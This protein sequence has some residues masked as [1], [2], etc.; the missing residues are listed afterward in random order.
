MADTQ[1]HRPTLS[2]LSEEITELSAS[3]GE[4]VVS[5]NSRGGFPTSG[6]IWEPG[7]VVTADHVLHLD[8]GLRVTLADGTDLEAELAGRDPSTDLALLKVA[9]SAQGFGSRTESGNLKPGTLAVSL[10]RNS[11]KSLNASLTVINAIGGE[12]RSPFGGTIDNYLRL[13]VTVHAGF[14]GGPLVDVSGALI[15]I[16]SSRLSRQSPVAIPLAT[17]ERVVSELKERGH[18]RQGY[19]GLA[20]FPI[21]IDEALRDRLK[22]DTADGLIVVQAEKG[23]GSER[24]GILQGDILVVLDGQAVRDPDELQAI[25]GPQSVGKKLSARVLRGGVLLDL[26]VEVGEKPIRRGGWEHHRRGPHDHHRRRHG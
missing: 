18:I 5:L 21:V 7:Y 26:E 11:E 24:A 10:G 9:S 1:Q 8:E 25:L 14:S 4:H 22:L 3:G 6:T 2:T 13:D 17:V 19:L 15:G 20:S 12:W 23:S 16:N